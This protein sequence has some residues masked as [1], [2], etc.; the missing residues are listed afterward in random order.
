MADVDLTVYAV[1][2]A[3]VEPA[4]VTADT[5]DTYHFANDGHEVL[6]VSNTDPGA[7]TI[8][9]NVVTVLEEEGLS[10][11]DR[12]K[13]I[14]GGDFEFMGPFRTRIYGDPVEFTLSGWDPAMVDVQIVVLR[15]AGF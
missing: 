4:L 11:A 15:V 14:L 9:L 12:T 7:P 1:T 3:G 5:A 6:F 8:A 13:N 2:P 10:L